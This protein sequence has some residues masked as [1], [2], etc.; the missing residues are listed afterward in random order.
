MP[1]KGAAAG[2]GERG[3]DASAADPGEPRTGVKKGMGQIS[4]GTGL[5]QNA[6]SQGN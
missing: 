4:Q 5:P 2:T 6:P 3:A 1:G